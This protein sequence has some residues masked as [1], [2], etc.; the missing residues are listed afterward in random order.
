MVDSYYKNVQDLNTL[1]RIPMCFYKEHLAVLK[2][3]H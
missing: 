3:T 2:P 1:R